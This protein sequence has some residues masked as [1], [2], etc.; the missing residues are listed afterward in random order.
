MSTKHIVQYLPM[1]ADMNQYN[2]VVTWIESVPW[3]G[4]SRLEKFYATV[5][6]GGQM[7]EE[8][9]RLLMRKWLVQAVAA[10]GDEFVEVSEAH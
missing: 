9:K 8:L 5:D 6:T 4:V 2:P 1:I 3:D 7:P 10:E